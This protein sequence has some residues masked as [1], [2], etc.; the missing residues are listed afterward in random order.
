[1]SPPLNQFVL[2]SSN[3]V[4]QDVWIIFWEASSWKF[5]Q[6]AQYLVPISIP[7]GFVLGPL[8]LIYM[9]LLGIIIHSDGLAFHCFRW[10]KIYITK[11]IS[12]A[13]HSTLTNCLTYINLC[14]Q[15][16]FY[17]CVIWNCLSFICLFLLHF[18][19]H[20]WKAFRSFLK[21]NL[22][23]KFININEWHVNRY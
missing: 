1:M 17:L 9:L 5:W 8:F 13:T 2:P 3:I 23:I 18:P 4:I 20:F 15:K 11:Y 10:V 12:A 6:E 7:Q 21:I 16:N 22:E 14:M 19:N